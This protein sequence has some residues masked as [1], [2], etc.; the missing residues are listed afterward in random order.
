MQAVEQ[1]GSARIAKVSIAF[2]EQSR[3]SEAERLQVRN[4]EINFFHE[5]K[6]ISFLPDFVSACHLDMSFG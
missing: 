2:R 6:N 1:R 3:G 5:F 4:T